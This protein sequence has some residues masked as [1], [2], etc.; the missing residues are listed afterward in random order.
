MSA[1]P[2]AAG[3]APA[4]KRRW[5]VGD[6][7][8]LPA[9]VEVLET[10]PSPI[11]IALLVTICA[12]VVIALAWSWFGRIDIVA[13][14]Q[15]KIQPLG[16]VKVI[17]PFETGRVREVLVING[18]SVRTGDVLVRLDPAEAEADVRAT[19]SIL[20]AYRAEALRRRTSIGVLQKRQPEPI[21]LINWPAE[22]PEDLRAR[23]T[24]VLNGEL[25][26]VA[27]VV[28]SLEAQR[29][30]KQA[31][32]ER[33]RSTIAA[34]KELIQIQKERVGMRS[35]LVDRGAGPRANL[36]DALESMRYQETILIT[37]T[38]QLAES[39]A[40]IEVL[41]REI[42]KVFEAYVSEN[43]QKLADAEK[44]IDDY[45]QRLAKAEV[46]LERM[47]L[48]SPIDGTVQSLTVSTVGQVVTTGVELMRVVPV[49]AAVEIE[50]YLPNKD[51]G[52]VS[53][54]QEAIIKIDAFPFTRYGSINAKVVRI[55]KDAMPEPEAQA[56]E[57][58]TPTQKRPSMFATPERTQNLVYP[59]TL[60][61]ET[62]Q[63]NADGVMVPL[64]P[65]M[66]VTAEVKTG[67][68]RIL[69]FVFSPLVEI[70]SKSMKER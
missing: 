50:C 36:L 21:P 20:A 33:L 46:R 53:V 38:G 63:I 16:S 35:E 67:S 40:N 31:E 56:L 47:T 42:G 45:E 11:R 58:N 6:H 4:K 24:R 19:R 12:F 49:D 66:A 34:Q 51:I 1:V 2:Q 13:S 54:G 52:F 70:A 60:V 28:A 10:P 39:E 30:Q 14:A 37:Q 57:G 9:A 43:S 3:P 59:I 25:T 5:E 41:G 23:E 65:G 32:S 69:E 26:Q 15:G 27:A 64:S 55:A 48:T 68:R 62:T 8:F 29:R 7:E 17:Q 44:Q 61:P 18:K 22:I